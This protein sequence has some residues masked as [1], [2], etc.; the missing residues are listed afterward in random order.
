M[1]LPLLVETLHRTCDDPQSHAL[2]R[3][4]DDDDDDDDL[5]VQIM[6]SDPAT[7]WHLFPQIM[8]SCKTTI[9]C[10]SSHA[11]HEKKKCSNGEGS[12]QIVLLTPI[13]H[14][15]R[16][17]VT[18]PPSRRHANAQRQSVPSRDIQ[19]T[20]STTACIHVKL[21][22]IRD[23]HS[24]MLSHARGNNMCRIIRLIVVDAQSRESLPD[25]SSDRGQEEMLDEQHLGS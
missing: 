8:I 22:C 7:S 19:G 13:S 3:L 5:T 20:K 17:S 1:L 12:F 9:F 15:Q 25:A 10:S 6:C 14:H 11:I 21:S 16:I 2:R 4:N 24:L 18:I 23:H